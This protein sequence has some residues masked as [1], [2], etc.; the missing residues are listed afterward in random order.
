[1]RELHITAGR[2]ESSM[3]KHRKLHSSNCTIFAIS[4][5]QSSREEWSSPR[6]DFAMYVLHSKMR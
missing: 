4:I 5:R 3:G 1:M 6:F 2:T